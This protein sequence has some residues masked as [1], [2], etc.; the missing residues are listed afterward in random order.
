MI[1][2]LASYP[3]SGNTWLRSLISTYF[4][5]KDG[6]F[7]F[8]L[9]DK[10]DQ[11]PNTKY[12]EKFDDPFL[13]P[14][15]S[16][17]YWLEVQSEINK[18]KKIKFLK[19]HSAL[20]TIDKNIFTDTKNSL[21]AI[22]ILRDP[23]NVITSISN[24]YGKN[25][26]EALNFMKDEKRVLLNKKDNRYLGFIALFSW[27]THQ[28]SWI[29]NKTFPTLVIRYEDLEH[30]TFETFKKVFLFIKNLTNQKIFFDREKAKKTIVSCNFENMKKLENEMG[31]PEAVIDKRSKQKI[32]F[33]NLGKENNF[34]KLLDKKTLD[35]MNIIFQD[36]LRKFDYD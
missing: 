6:K 15:S 20:C 17:K 36:Q 16:S 14:E 19:T 2:W 29:E 30:R 23:R 3:K 5:T 4:Y 35:E 10:I 7:N 25:I 28:K 21:G 22:Y 31:F 8:Q 9:L 26:E 12:F 24:H 11:F 13:K 18:D 1:I 33:F 27:I 32:N 34:N